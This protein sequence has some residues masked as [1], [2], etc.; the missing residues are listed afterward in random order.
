MAFEKFQK[1]KRDKNLHGARSERE[2]ENQMQEIEKAARDAMTQDQQTLR[3]Q[4]YSNSS[5]SQTS[6]PP[7]P[8]PPNFR[9]SDSNHREE[10][11]VI[12]SHE[13]S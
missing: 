5:S 1:D 6:K 2:L 3:G 10:N 13:E 12:D 11:L 8:P 9:T 4:F 7:P